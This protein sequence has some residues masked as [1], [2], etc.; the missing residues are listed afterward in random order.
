MLDYFFQPNDKQMKNAL[1]SIVLFVFTA[2]N[3][4]RANQ[5]FVERAIHEESYTQPSLFSPQTLALA[6]F[7]LVML[8]TL[9]L[10]KSNPRKSL[11]RNL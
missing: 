8:V 1:Y 7:V 5:V 10:W 3:G 9:I 6:C 2:L 4:A 11:F